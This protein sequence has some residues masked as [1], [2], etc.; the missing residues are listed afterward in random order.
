M[1]NEIRKMFIYCFMI[2][3]I[4]GIAFVNLIVWFYK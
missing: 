2:P 1:K 4:T 3:V